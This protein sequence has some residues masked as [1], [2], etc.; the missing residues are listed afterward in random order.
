MLESGWQVP[1]VG[2]GVLQTNGLKVVGVQVAVA[3]GVGVKVEVGA[4][5]FVEVG[6]GVAVEVAGSERV[7]VGVGV[8]VKGADKVGVALGR[9]RIVP[10]LGGGEVVNFEVQAVGIR[11]KKPSTG[12]KKAVFFIDWFL[13][14]RV[15]NSLS[16]I[17]SPLRMNYSMFFLMKTGLFS[18]KAAAKACWG[19]HKLAG[20]AGWPPG[21][22]EQLENI[23]D[24]VVDHGHELELGLFQVIKKGARNR[25]GGKGDEVAHF[26]EAHPDPRQADV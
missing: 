21:S 12:N 19:T 18:G 7:E 14:A 23:P 13:I 1:A 16:T 15:L 26:G 3:E 4:V 22:M 10:P 24:V 17:M 8:W 11:A 5:V 6:D 2:M 25:Q 20:S 9:Q